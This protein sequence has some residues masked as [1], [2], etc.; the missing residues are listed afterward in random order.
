MR[1][2]LRIYETCIQE[3]KRKGKRSNCNTQ[4]DVQTLGAH[5]QD[6]SGRGSYSVTLNT[7]YMC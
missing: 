2:K 3:M 5:L 6:I 4:H 1:S 7:Y